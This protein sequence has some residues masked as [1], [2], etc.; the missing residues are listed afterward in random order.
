MLLIA[1]D[2]F[3][4]FDMLCVAM[5]TT[6]EHLTMK[7]YLITLDANLVLC[8]FYMQYLYRMVDQLFYEI[9]VSNIQPFDL[10]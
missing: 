8:V 1:K 5:A 2:E 7:P 6:F 10:L 9:K 3:C 4:H